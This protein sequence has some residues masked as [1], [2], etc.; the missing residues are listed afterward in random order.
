M[1]GWGQKKPQ[2]LKD[3]NNTTM[4]EEGC[5]DCLA[6]P[7]RKRSLLE[8]QWAIDAL[9]AGVPSFWPFSPAQAHPNCVC[10]VVPRTYGSD[11]VVAH[12]VRRRRA[13]LHQSVKNSKDR[14]PNARIRL[15]S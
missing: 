5:S 11:K 6:P 8:D 1:E 4:A 10:L 14:L 9:T 13:T 2:T 7:R 3:L 12:S 15:E